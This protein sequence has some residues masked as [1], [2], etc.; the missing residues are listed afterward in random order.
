MN[1]RKGLP[2]LAASAACLVLLVG[3]I[4]VIAV[5]E[6]PPAEAV[7][8]P[9]GAEPGVAVFP[10]DFGVLDELVPFAGGVAPMAMDVVPE[11]H[12][13]EFRDAAWVA[14]EDPAAFTLQVLAARDEEVV[15]R[16]LADREDRADFA[17]FV[18]PQEDGNWFVL[19]TG[20]YAS[21]ELAN[22]VA[23]GKS[24]GSAST[25]PFPRRMS[26]Y[27]EALKA[28]PAA[29]PPPAAPVASPPAAPA[30]AAGSSPAP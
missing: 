5:K 20:R 8:L 2:F 26:A 19:T 16:F 4:V 23:E 13:P 1:W 7:A 24:L 12:A 9:V 18:F 11:Q 25:R 30:P 3:S 17:Y 21:P 14:A 6:R 10:R 27:Q 22:S 15:K 28:A 29:A